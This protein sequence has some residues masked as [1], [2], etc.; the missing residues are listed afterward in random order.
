MQINK[1]LGIHNAIMKKTKDFNEKQVAFD[2][3][4]IRDYLV[5]SLI[6]K[7]R[8]EGSVFDH[9]ASGYSAIEWED[10]EASNDRLYQDFCGRFVDYLLERK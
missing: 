10:D 4:S 5:E 8:S 2:R 1:A 9:W 3:A 7:F 6:D